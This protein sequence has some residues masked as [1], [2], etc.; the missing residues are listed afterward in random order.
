[1]NDLNSIVFGGTI[2]SMPS[3]SD[4]NGE[5]RCSFV[6][7]SL[8]RQYNGNGRL[9]RCCET[10]VRPVIFSGE[11]VKAAKNCALIGRGVRVVGHLA[12]AEEENN[13]CIVADHIEYR[14]DPDS[15]RRK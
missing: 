2:V 1:M 13:I 15:K 7:S 5:K 8:W 3:V 6:V 12:G 11:L 10:R 4:S 9:V 14:P